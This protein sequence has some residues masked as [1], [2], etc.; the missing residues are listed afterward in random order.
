[1][2][3]LLLSRERIEMLLGSFVCILPE[4]S[5]NAR[6]LIL[7]R[8]LDEPSRDDVRAEEDEGILRSGG[9]LLGFDASKAAVALR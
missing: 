5:G 2:L 6:D 1:M 3:S 7:L 9:T 8:S 4:G